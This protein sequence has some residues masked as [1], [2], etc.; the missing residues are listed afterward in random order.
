MLLPEDAEFQPT[1][2]SPLTLP[3]GLPATRP[4]P[5]AAAR[6]ERETDTM[7][8][9]MCSSWYFSAATSSPHYD[10]APLR[11][12]SWRASWLPV[13]QYTGG[14]EHA[15]MHLLYSRFF[16]KA[17]R[18]IGLRRLRRAL[19][20]PVQPGH[21]LG[22][23]GQKMSKSRGNVVNPD[24]YVDALGRRHRPLLPDVHRPLGPGRPLGPI[25]A[26][27]ASHR[28][29]NRVWNLVAAIAAQTDAADARDRPRPDPPPDAQDHPPRHRRHRALPLQ[30][31]ARRA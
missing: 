27:T 15:I 17:I 7:D 5:A 16:T 19:P 4:A 9:F 24:D 2:E 31:H 11:P 29:L 23:H 12:A 1:G 14:I 13:D 3:R 26:S 25:A 22:P 10:E 6:A 8:T 21:I 20:A 30:H 28:W 18:D